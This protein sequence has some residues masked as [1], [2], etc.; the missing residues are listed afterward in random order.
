MHHIEINNPNDGDCGFYAFA[1]GLLHLCLKPRPSFIHERW[2]S[3]DAES[4]SALKSFFEIHDK[5]HSEKLSQEQQTK[6]ILE[7]SKALTIKNPV[8]RGQHIQ[9]AFAKEKLNTCYCPSL[10]NH[11]NQANLVEKVSDLGISAEQ[12]F[13]QVCEQEDYALIRPLKD[14]MKRILQKQQI[15][16]LDSLS[17]FNWSD[18]MQ[19]EETKLYREFH[20]LV[21]HEFLPHN[22]LASS[23]ALKA[24]ARGIAEEVDREEDK[25]FRLIKTNAL[26]LKAFKLGYSDILAAINKCYAPETVWHASDAELKILAAVFGVQIEIQSKHH[27]A[28]LTEPCVYIENI[29]KKH[30]RTRIYPENGL[31]KPAKKAL[32]NRELLLQEAQAQL[33]K[34]QNSDQEVRR[35]Q[36]LNEALIEACVRADVAD[37]DIW[38]LQLRRDCH[39]NLHEFLL[40]PYTGNSR[41]YSDYHQAVLANLR[42][43]AQL[44]QT[45][46]NID[47]LKLVLN[48]EAHHLQALKIQLLQ[49]LSGLVPKDIQA[50]NPINFSSMF[51]KVLN[52]VSPSR[53]SLRYLY[54]SAV[55]AGAGAL[56]VNLIPGVLTGLSMGLGMSLVTAN[57]VF[58]LLG[59]YLA[60][61]ITLV[62][63]IYQNERIVP[64][65]L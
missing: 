56:I 2:L 33:G 31:V 46:K 40:K 14:S 1:I 44:E 59:L 64:H 12:W 16:E 48:R 29:S 4:A 17:Q 60:N 10:V 27:L 5:E 25:D 50:S 58:V 6:L 7:L 43:Q 49:E 24:L 34:Y 63:Q 32:I 8:L 37:K 23:E 52:Q 62:H 13:R 61:I 53:Y 41:L 26:V 9:S 39:I 22:I 30:W 35:Y 20:D 54:A 55:G 65:P 51:K 47:D 57:L 45:T 42:V 18:F 28:L 36:E 3:L 11:L 19:I 38:A 15:H 21:L